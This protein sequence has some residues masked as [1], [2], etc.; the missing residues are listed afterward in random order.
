[1]KK[2]RDTGGK[3]ERHKVFNEVGIA[4]GASRG[5]IAGDDDDIHLGY[6]LRGSARIFVQTLA[7]ET[8]A[9][10]AEASDLIDIVKAKIQEREGI[11]ADHQRLIFAGKSLEAGWTLSDYNIQNGST[12]HLALRLR[13]GM[14]VVVSVIIIMRIMGMIIVMSA[15]GVVKVVEVMMISFKNANDSDYDNDSDN[16]NDNHNG[17]DDDN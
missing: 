11:S 5:V 3:K 14:L 13:G 2:M 15:T 4:S 10:A 16:D 12:L 9:I 8:I 17:D 1:M 6:R 7:G